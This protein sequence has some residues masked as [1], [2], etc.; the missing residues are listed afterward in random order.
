MDKYLKIDIKP[1]ERRPALIGILKACLPRS[2]GNV[3]IKIF[4]ELWFF[5]F[6]FDEMKKRKEE[7]R[8]KGN[9]NRERERK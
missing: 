8:K 1:W 4:A 3:G 5:F 9:D 6:F 7:R 2:W